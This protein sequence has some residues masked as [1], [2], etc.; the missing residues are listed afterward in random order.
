LDRPSSHRP[1]EARNNWVEECL[2]NDGYNTAIFDFLNFLHNWTE[3][4][5]KEK[6]DEENDLG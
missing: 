6:P 5:E 1:T 4:L 3:F 2:Y